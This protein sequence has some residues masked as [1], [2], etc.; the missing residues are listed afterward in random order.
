MAEDFWFFLSY[1]RI[2]LDVH[3]KRFRQ[4]LAVLVRS[5]G[6]V[7]EPD[8]QK[9][10]FLDINNLE[11]GRDW[12][13]DLGSALEASRVLVP[14]YS[15]NYFQREYCGKEFQAFL[16]PAVAYAAGQQAPAARAILP[17]L[18]FPVS[19]PPKISKL[20]IYDEAYPALYRQ[21]GLQFLMDTPGHEAEYKAF[22]RVLAERIV[23]EGKKAAPPKTPR[24]R[25]KRI[26]DIQAVFPEAVQPAKPL[27]EQRLEF[28]D[29]DLRIVRFI[30][31]AAKRGEVGRTAEAYGPKGGIDWKPFAPG[32]PELG[33]RIAQEAASK[34]KFLSDVKPLD[35]RLNAHL[36][37]A[38]DEELIVVVLVDPW[39]LTN[40]NYRQLIAPCDQFKP[41]FA[42]IVAW[43]LQDPETKE[44]Q[45]ALVMALQ[46]AL[47][48]L[49]VAI[50]HPVYFR[51]RADT[52]D[53][54]QAEIQSTLTELYMRLVQARSAR[55]GLTAQP[56]P[57]VSNAQEATIG[58]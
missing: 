11:Q 56:P 47:P 37:E 18:L 19:P 23:A 2:E 1:A 58:G 10:G 43:N 40:Q 31:G 52:R 17:V 55:L 12:T 24:A 32:D 35:Q 44:Q 13:A 27:Q 34:E 25:L 22:L 9:V 42:V 41:S 49:A 3:I 39:S 28:T 54:L 8:D 21:K 30:C 48:N 16:D 29:D 4:E 53:R 36:K 46:Q 20:Q 5:L 15:P 6:G 51:E 38:E 14:L 57:S 7:Q 26:E 33:A 50:R 45:P